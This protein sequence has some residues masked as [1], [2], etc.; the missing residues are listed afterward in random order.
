MD[1][2]SPAFPQRLYT[3]GDEPEPGKSIGYYSNDTKLFA[4]LTKVLKPDELQEIRDSRLGVCL[5]FNQ[6]KFEWA[7]RLVHF[8][9]GFQLVCNKKYEIWSLVGTQPLRFSLNEFQHI[10]GLNCEHVDSLEQPEVE[11]TEELEE[12]WEKLGVS[13]DSGPSIDQLTQA[14]KSAECWDRDD[15]IRLGYL[16]IYAGFIEARKPSTPTRVKMARLVMDVDAFV[17]Y[18]WGRVAFKNLIQSVKE[19]D[20]AKSSYTI[21]GF[22]EVIQMWVYESMPDLALELG[23]PFPNNPTPPLLAYRGSRGRKNLKQALLRQVL[24]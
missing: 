9:L 23:E 19:K 6:L 17:N 5:L 2:E 15:R 11:V 1:P 22:V 13:M 12:F 20:I 4:E 24:T 16:A 3:K 7:S 18:P 8:M 10:T 21:D 14:C